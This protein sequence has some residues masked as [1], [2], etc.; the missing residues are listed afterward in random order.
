MLK[1]WH[2]SSLIE[3]ETETEVDGAHT[4]HSQIT[5]FNNARQSSS[6]PSNQVYGDNRLPQTPSGLVDHNS[7]F[8]PGLVNSSYIKSEQQTYGQQQ[9]PQQ[10]FGQTTGEQ[11][12]TPYSYLPSQVPNGLSGYSM[13]PMTSVPDYALYSNEAQRAA[14]GYYDPSMLH[15]SPSN[16]SASTYQTREKYNHDTNN[17]TAQQNSSAAGN[18]PTVQAQHQQHAYAN[19]PYYPYYYMPNQFQGYQQPGYGQPFVNKNMY[20]MYQHGSKPTASSPYAA[21]GSPYQHHYSPVASYDDLSVSHQ[22]GMVHD[23]QKHYGT[24]PQYQTYMGQPSAQAGQGQGQ[25]NGKNDLNQYGKASNVQAGG[26]GSNASQS[27]HVQQQ[28]QQSSMYAGQQQAMYSPYQYSQQQQPHR[29]PQTQPQGTQPQG[30]GQ[31]QG[32]Q[33]AGNQPYWTQ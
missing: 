2:C 11:H 13:N 22:H 26:A 15:H 14:M 28:Q 8:G 31:G 23:Y 27:Q 19:V 6:V 7:N 29:Q 24:A 1:S 30:N 3:K 33:S 10:N 16:T 32:P 12:N 20:P 25:Q 21:A 4:A 18:N 17:S 9:P 5:D